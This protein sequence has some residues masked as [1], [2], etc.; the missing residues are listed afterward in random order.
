M[1][2]FDNFA[3]RLW[4]VCIVIPFKICKF[5]GSNLYKLKLAETSVPC[6]SPCVLAHF[7]YVC[8]RNFTGLCY[9]T[10]VN[11]CTLY[12]LMLVPTHFVFVF[13][14]FLSKYIFLFSLFVY[15][16]DFWKQGKSLTLKCFHLKA[17]PIVWYIDGTMMMGCGL[18][19]SAQYISMCTEM[20]VC[21]W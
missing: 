16:F 17:E 15:L 12:W 3:F 5:L 4:I 19:L 10:N 1:D 6:W 14:L 18:L 7:V 20:L 11:L 9:D 2:R 13:C 8:H 21:R